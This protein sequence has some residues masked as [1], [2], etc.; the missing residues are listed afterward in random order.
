M[1]ATIFLI[2]IFSVLSCEPRDDY[3]YDVRSPLLMEV[4]NDEFMMEDLNIDVYSTHQ[5][6][7]IPP[8]DQKLIKD[9]RIRFMCENVGDTKNA[10]DSISIT[11]GAYS[12][13]ESQSHE[14]N[15]LIY[16]H[17]LRVPAKNFDEMLNALEKLALKVDF[18][19]INSNDVSETYIDID[20]RL[21]TK[22]DLESRYLEILKKADKVSEILS[23]E[24]EIGD[25]RAEIE[26]LQGRMNYLRSQVA[27]STINVMYY[28]PLGE[29]FGYDVKHAIASG[30]QNLI[31][32]LIAM[33]N[34]WPFILIA[35]SVLIW[36]WQ[37]RKIVAGPSAQ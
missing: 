12:S 6:Q 30:T 36:W 17:T 31:S 16:H 37:R 7:S 2:L 33:F 13:T 20:S 26:S 34:F 9:C 10:L 27:Y 22:I 32:L 5:I 24:R 15:D 28:Q 8:V 4:A 23:V 21:K 35:G 14:G 11:M 1:K 19:E 29:G 25:V 18:K 3:A